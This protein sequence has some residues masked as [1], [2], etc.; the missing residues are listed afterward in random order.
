FRDT[1]ED[2]NSAVILSRV[3]ARK[4]F[5][6]GSA[7][8]QS[9]LCAGPKEKPKRVVGV[10]EENKYLTVRDNQ[11]TL[12]T[13]ADKWSSTFLIR[14]SGNA[15]DIVAR[16]GKVLR[17][18]APDVPLGTPLAM[19]KVVGRTLAT[20]RLL[21]T[22]GNFFG[23]LALLLMAIGLYGTL[24]YMTSRR[25]PEIGVRMALGASQGSVVWTVI[26]ENLAVVSMGVVLGLCAV[27]LSVRYVQ[28]FLYGVQTYDPMLLL[29]ATGLI[30]VVAAIATGM[31]ALR[32]A[33]IDPMSAL[34]SE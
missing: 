34:R 14:Y 11:S 23:A 32:A 26:R 30:G 24:A 5:P 12:F 20:E 33:R 4:L 15:K 21:A 22:L 28:S 2:R 10:V 7:V 17:K 19:D 25:T 3:T 6:H 8:G 29:T 31:P 9:V 18:I 16:V 1:P 27:A 13:P